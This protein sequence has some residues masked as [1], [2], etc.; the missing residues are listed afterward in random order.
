LYLMGDLWIFNNTKNQWKWLTGTNESYLYVSGFGTQFVQSDIGNFIS[1]NDNFVPIWGYGVLYF[2]VPENDDSLYFYGGKLKYNWG[3]TNLLVEYSISRNQWRFISGVADE[4]NLYQTSTYP[5]GLADGGTFRAENGTIYV[6]GGL[7]PIG[8]G[9]GIE[10]SEDIWAFTN[11]TSCFGY[12]KY[13]LENVCSGHGSCID[14]D[15]CECVENY[16]GDECEKFKC[17]GNLF[18]DPNVCSDNGNCV[19]INNCTC[20]LGYY[21]DNCQ[22]SFECYGLFNNESDVCT[23]HGICKAFNNCSCDPNYSGNECEVWY[24]NSI[25]NTNPSVCSSKGNCTGHNLCQCTPQYCGTYCNLPACFGI[26]SNDDD[27]CSPD[28]FFSGE[29]FYPG[30]CTAPDTCECYH[31]EDRWSF[32]SDD[33]KQWHCNGIDSEDPNVCSGNGGGFIIDSIQGFSNYGCSPE[34][35]TRGENNGTCWCKVDNT[36]GCLP[37]P[38]QYDPKDYYGYDCQ[39]PSCGE[40]WISVPPCPDWEYKYSIAANDPTVCSGEGQCISLNNCSCNIGYTGPLCEDIFTCYG[41]PGNTLLACSGGGICSSNDTCVCLEGRYGNECEHKNDT[42]TGECTTN[43]DCYVGN[44]VSGDCD[45][46]GTNHYGPLCSKWDCGNET[47]GFGHIDHPFVC[48]ENGICKSNNLTNQYCDCFVETNLE[49]CQ[50]PVCFGKTSNDRYVCYGHG[51][52]VENNRCNCSESEPDYTIWDYEGIGGT[53]FVDNCNN[54]ICD[55][56]RRNDPTS[57]SGH[58]DCY[59]LN[60]CICDTGYAGRYCQRHECFGID[61]NSPEVCSGYGECTYRDNCV[62]QVGVIGTV[63][64]SFANCYGKLSTDPTV[65]SGNGE[66]TEDDHCVC[67]QVVTNT[68]IATGRECQD[69]G[70]ET[71]VWHDVNPTNF[72]YSKGIFG[73]DFANFNTSQFLHPGSR[74]FGSSWTN[75][76]FLIFGGLGFDDEGTLGPLGDFWEFDFDADPNDNNK[77]GWNSTLYDESQQKSNSTGVKNEVG[78]EIKGYPPARFG[79]CTGISENNNIIYLFGGSRQSFELEQLLDLRHFKNFSQYFNKILLGDLWY[80]EKVE[81]PP[82]NEW[83]LLSDSQENSQ[84][85]IENYEL[86]PH[87]FNSLNHP[88]A[89]A[90]SKCFVKQNQFHVLGGIGFG[91]STNPLLGLP[92]PLFDHWVYNLTTLKWRLVGPAF[93]PPLAATT[94]DTY[95]GN[96]IT[97]LFSFGG[98]SILG[99]A[100]TSRRTI[101]DDL[102]G[103]STQSSDGILSSLFYVINLN[104]QTTK[105]WSDSGFFT[106][107]TNFDLNDLISLNEVLTDEPNWAGTNAGGTAWHQS[108]QMFVYGGFKEIDQI[109]GIS[110]NQNLQGDLHLQNIQMF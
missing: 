94:G 107:I 3:W 41:N 105:V 19:G 72:P 103:F 2:N 15:V 61:S 8:T 56:K 76:S 52:C 67:D 16:G 22:S 55:G 84:Y 82:D 27:V 89:R 108:G 77:P 9:T 42:Y 39:I 68:Y 83:T 101:V 5:G 36:L 29:R 80:E 71:G 26:C 69:V 73:N 57:C 74:F 21:G 38:G 50:L 32:Y 81:T 51:V 4:L 58:G 10:V 86:Y 14:Y 96:E 87:D 18:D 63:C 75:G 95:N 60:E 59:L 45:C 1:G 33:C 106:D 93:I 88:G 48:F 66:C 35:F 91:I 100:P 54:T 109:L 43:A 92:L 90:F 24:C 79:A 37:Y 40:P 47:I 28:I 110:T 17:F 98:S 49:F 31:F 44:C 99:P 23:G 65:C 12:S 25:L 64:E 70:V 46:S 53:I 13:D 30:T 78:D 20:D 102:L 34:G 11:L 104:T 7:Y 6:Y 62:C 97:S 85:N